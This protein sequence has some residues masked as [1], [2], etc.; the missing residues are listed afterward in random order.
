MKITPPLEKPVFV[1]ETPPMEEG[2]YYHGGGRGGFTIMEEKGFYY[3]G[4]GGVL[5]S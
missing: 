4:G 5:L 2:F 3:H 1:L